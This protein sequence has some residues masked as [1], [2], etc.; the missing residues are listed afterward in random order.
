MASGDH[1]GTVGDRLSPWIQA[2]NQGRFT[3][4]L[5][6]GRYKI[7]AKAE[8]DGYPD[9]VFMLNNDPSREFPEISVMR[10]SIQ[11]LRVVLGRRGA[12][13]G[14][15]VIDEESGSP[16]PHSKV[17]IRDA[18]N[19]NAYVEVF[20]DIDGNFKF[21]VPSK[22]LLISASAVGFKPYNPAERNEI[23]IPS[24]E[25]RDVVLRLQRQ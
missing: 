6:P 7:R 10:E 11:G 20:T 17:T 14:G 5:V 8:P 12:I 18:L 16:I 9:P 15:K 4:N 25:Q 19:T 21:T 23:T 1:I 24:G 3:L 22:P 13:L 2:D